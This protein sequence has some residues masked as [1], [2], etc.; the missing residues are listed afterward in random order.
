VQAHGGTVC[1]DSAPGRGS[2]FIVELPR[3]TGRAASA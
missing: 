1:L 2:T 3:Q